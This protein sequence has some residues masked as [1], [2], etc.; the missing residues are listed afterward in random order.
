MKNNLNNNKQTANLVKFIQNIGEKNY[1]K[2]NTWLQKA[3]ENKLLNKISN[4]KNINIF[5]Q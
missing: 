3:V 5:K 4:A 2:A 1:A